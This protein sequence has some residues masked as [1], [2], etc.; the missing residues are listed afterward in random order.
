MGGG[1]PNILERIEMDKTSLTV[2]F[3]T[4][5]EEFHIGNAIDNVKDI[6]SEIFVVD[7]LSVDRTVDIALE[8]GAKVVQRPFTDFGDQWNFALQKLPIQTFWTMKMDPDERL[9]DEL[10]QQIR[11]G[12]EHT[13]ELVGFEFDRVLWFMETPQ[14]NLKGRVLR[15]WQTGRCRFTDVA[16]NEHPMVDGPVG[17]LPGV[18]QHLDS[19]DLAHWVDKQNMY[20]SREAL[21]RYHKEPLAERGRLFGNG[22]QRRM[23]FK[24]I[25]YNIPGRYVLWFFYCYFIQ[26][27]WLNGRVGLCWAQMRVFAM[28]LIE[29]KWREMQI[30]GREVKLPRNPE[31]HYHSRIIDSPLQKLVMGTPH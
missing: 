8:K 10:K 5:N 4:L 13:S 19:P 6:A 22:L 15:I 25:F 21:I 1:S 27:A 18:M 30:T 26:G 29:Y 28:R 7:S 20:T 9:T 14:P 3:L 24:K 11:N 16:V 12:I 31:K 23:F 17:F 2:V